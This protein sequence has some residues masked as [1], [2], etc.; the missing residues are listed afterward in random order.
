MN[1]PTVITAF[2][3]AAARYDSK[4]YA[5]CFSENAVVHDEGASYK[6]PKEIQQWNEDTN[7]KYMPVSEPVAFTETADTAILATKVSGNF[8]GSPLV[9]KYHFKLQNGL[10]DAL[11]ITS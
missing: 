6:G 10:I 8:P 11:E 9:L 1:L 5:D 3:A 4:A 7:K 2:L